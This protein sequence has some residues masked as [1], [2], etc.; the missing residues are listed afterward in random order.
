MLEVGADTAHQPGV[1]SLPL[2]VSNIRW[3]CLP[4]RTEYRRRRVRLTSSVAKHPFKHSPSNS[5][6]MDVE[7]HI[8]S[9]PALPALRRDFGNIKVREAARGFLHEASL[10]GGTRTVPPPI[11]GAIPVFS[12]L[13]RPLFP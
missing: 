6:R 9:G 7:P 8:L 1:H 10:Y 13:S 12:S 11:K 5:N 4:E 3:P 2:P